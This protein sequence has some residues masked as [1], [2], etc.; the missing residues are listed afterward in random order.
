MS[1]ADDNSTPPVATLD[2]PSGTGK[3]TV[4]SLLARELGWHFLDSGSLYRAVG[5]AALQDDLDTGAENGTA[6]G[7]LARDLALRFE[8]QP[9]G[10]RIWMRGSEVTAALRTPEVAEA[11]SQVASIPEVRDGLLELQRAFR[12]PPGLVA[13]GR[14][15]GSVVFPRTPAK[16]FLTATPDERARRRYEQLREQGGDVNLDQIKADLKARDQ[17]DSQREVAPMRPPEGAFVVDTT[18]LS[19]EE[20]LA[21]VLHH[22]RQALPGSISS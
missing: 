2:G 4:G 21:E 6:L 15:M 17:R 16:F 13:D 8:P 18:E 20:V 7:E 1:G 22:L 12:R 10:V 11:A 19:I 5:L 14:D 3:G 9:E